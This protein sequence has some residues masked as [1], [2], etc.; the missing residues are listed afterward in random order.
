[1]M[2]MFFKR[3]VGEAIW[4]MNYSIPKNV[5]FVPFYFVWF[6]VLVGYIL[7]SK[8]CIINKVR[9]SLGDYSKDC[10]DCIGQ[11]LTI[12]KSMS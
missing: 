9:I 5:H 4:V 8:T 10:E 1:M 7:G 6:Q 3:V 2:V 11:R 12:M